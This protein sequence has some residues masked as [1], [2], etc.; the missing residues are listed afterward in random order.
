[1]TVDP[2]THNPQL[3][4]PII[5]SLSFRKIEDITAL[6]R[7]G[8][9]DKQSDTNNNRFDNTLN[10]NSSYGL[11]TIHMNGKDHYILNK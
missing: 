1:M 3:T 5:F 9:V 6:K 10:N 4:L 8:V 7:E 2:I 11:F